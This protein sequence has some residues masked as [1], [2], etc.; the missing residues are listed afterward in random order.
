MKQEK[1]SLKNNY[2]S[3]LNHIWNK[4]STA[5]NFEKLFQTAANQ[6]IGWLLIQTTRFNEDL[7]APK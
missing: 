7:N 2:G 5:N 4:G 1:Q 3:P 6:L